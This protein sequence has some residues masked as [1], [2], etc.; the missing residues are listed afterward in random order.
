MVASLIYIHL[1]GNVTPGHQIPFVLNE[2]GTLKLLVSEVLNVLELLKM[3]T[4]SMKWL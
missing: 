2:W 4:L 3:Q 1:F